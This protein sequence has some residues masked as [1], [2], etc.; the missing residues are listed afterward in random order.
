[1]TSP[2]PGGADF[3]GTDETDDTAA[4]APV[5]D[6][7]QVAGNT[8]RKLLI[9]VGAGAILLYVFNATPIGRQIR[10]WDTLAAIFNAP[11]WRGE[12][13]FIAIST[14]LTAAGVPRL[15]FYALGGFVFGFWEGLLW[16]LCSSLA[17]SFIAFRAARW[18][19]RA[20]LVEHFGRR[21]FFNRIAHAEPT[22]ASVA[23]MRML[24]VSNAIINFGLALSHAGNRA[25]LLGSLLGFLPQGIV[26]AIV[27]SGIA[28]DVPWAGAWQ[29]G[30]A[31]ILL[32]GLFAWSKKRRSGHS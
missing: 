23:L 27:G 13:H 20:W 28:K 11:G 12:L 17:G 16:S 10:D 2:A 32:A 31:G 14:L 1:M 29:I 5:P 26:A 4:D 9:L 7:E 6:L 22:V 19:G 25:F 24:P 15:L 3:P 30:G 21:R 18:G 8:S